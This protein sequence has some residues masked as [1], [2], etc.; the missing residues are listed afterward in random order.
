M[1]AFDSDFEYA[2]AMFDEV[3]GVSVTLVRGAAEAIIT[4]TPSMRD[5][6]VEDADGIV[7]T[8]HSRDYA[9]DADP[10]VAGVE[11]VP[12]PGDQIKETIRGVVNVFEVMGIGTRPAVEWADTN[13][14]RL[15]VHTKRIG[16]ST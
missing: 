8:I 2:E 13:G 16:T 4:A 9:I 3:F 14:T 5:Y 10:I 1:S 15:L 11:I 12:R 7:T 6:L